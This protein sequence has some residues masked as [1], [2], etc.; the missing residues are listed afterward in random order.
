MA[1][2][3][4][5]EWKLMVVDDNVNTL[6]I[7][8][9]I[10]SQEG[11]QVVVS[12]S[13]QDAI[14]ILEERDVDLVITDHKMPKA[15]GLEL[16]KHLRANHND[17]G[18][19]MI[20]GYPSIEGAVASI[21]EGADE[22]LVK[23]FTDNELTECVEGVLDKLV[24]T[25]MDRRKGSLA[26]TYGIIGDSKEMRRVFGM[27]EKASSTSVNVLISGE[28]GTGKE[29]V[30]RAIHYSGERSAS[31][32]V[33]VNCTAI[34][35][36]LLESELFGHVR[37]AFTGASDSR[38][39]FFQVAD[40]GT[41]LLDEIGDA[42][43]NMQGKLLRVLQN[44]EIFMVGSS[45]PRKVDVRILAAT[46]KDLPVL[47]KKGHFREDLYYRLAVLDIFVPPLKTRKDDVLLLTTYFMKKFSKEMNRPAPSFSENALEALKSYSWP[48]NVR[49]L[50]NL[51]QK[52]A[53]LVDSDAIKVSDLPSPMRFS[54]NLNQWP[55]RSLA[56]VE[57]DH[58]LNVLA[59]VGGNK[60][61]AAKILGIDRKT[62]RTKIQ[63]AGKTTL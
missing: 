56:Q 19:I 5:R 58:I 2:S 14:N 23:P 44:K 1:K 34:P 30:A 59:S 43:L 16:V 60:T 40:G 35:D 6:E 55:H 48:G 62:L 10:L 3:S 36:G 28:S 50:E 49:E 52:L 29:L 42:S 12:S 51:I 27:I 25:K 45:R 22:Y 26:E 61:H 53:V 32:F 54:I 57:A 63:R 18:I 13:V 11:Y 41:I 7:L 47:I 39:G 17:V 31:P 21:K 20:T 9:R 15:S 4:N 8:N 37:G 33:S 24:V 38:A 46:H